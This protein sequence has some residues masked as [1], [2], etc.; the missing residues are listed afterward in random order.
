MTSVARNTSRLQIDAGIVTYVVAVC[1]KAIVTLGCNP[2]RSPNPWL[3]RSALAT[4][5][6]H[7][8]P[9]ARVLESQS[10]TAQ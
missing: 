7:H 9:K 10:H 5:C 2:G 8:A 6:C 4:E 3:Q 1:Y